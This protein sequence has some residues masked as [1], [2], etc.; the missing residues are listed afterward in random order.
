MPRAMRCEVLCA[1]CT[2]GWFNGMGIYTPLKG[3]GSIRPLPNVHP[4]YRRGVQGCGRA[5][6]GGISAIST[7]PYLQK[8]F[9]TWLAL[10]SSEAFP[11]AE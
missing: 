4:R 11:S 8:I 6:E 5:E 10:L 3:H 1:R 9:Q 2:R 7:V